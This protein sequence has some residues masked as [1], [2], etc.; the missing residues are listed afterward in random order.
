MERVSSAKVYNS[1]DIL[2]RQVFLLAAAPASFSLFVFSCCHL[3]CAGIGI[4]TIWQT[5]SKLKW[6]IVL[7]LFLFQIS[8]AIL[9]AASSC[10]LTQLRKLE[11]ER[12]C[13]CMLA[14]LRSAVLLHHQGIGY[15]SLICK[16]PPSSTAAFLVS[17]HF[18]KKDIAY[19]KKEQEACQSLRKL[20]STYN[21]THSASSLYSKSSPFSN[22]PYFDL[23]SGQKAADAVASLEQ[24]WYIRYWFWSTTR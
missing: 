14:L 17:K 6:M 15:W 8:S 11:E 21:S 7:V 1:N 9:L 24:S 2:V 3:S 19:L 4:V 22:L 18:L 23:I 10:R 13:L 12:K 5:Q 16:H 20:T